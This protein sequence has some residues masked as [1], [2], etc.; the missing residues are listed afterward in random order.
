M[1]DLS[2]T[3]DRNNTEGATFPEIRMDSDFM[4]L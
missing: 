3:H 2:F 4:M 1:P